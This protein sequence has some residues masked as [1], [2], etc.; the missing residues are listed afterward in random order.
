MQPRRQPHLRAREVVQA[1]EAELRV[2]QKLHRLAAPEEVRRRLPLRLRVAREERV[3]VAPRRAGLRREELQLLDGGRLEAEAADGA[4]DE[5]PEV[6]LRGDVLAAQLVVGHRRQRDV[7]D[8]REQRR[9]E[10]RASRRRRLRSRRRGRW[11]RAARRG[12]RWC[13]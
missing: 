7:G 10:L 1:Q 11:R 6:E 12:T 2:V 9:R 5:E 13:W 3:A 4:E 8:E